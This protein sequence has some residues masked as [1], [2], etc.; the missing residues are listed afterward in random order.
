MPSISSIGRFE[1][2]AAGLAV[3]VPVFPGALADFPHRGVHHV[4]I[5][6]IDLNIRAAGVLIFVERFLPGFAAVGGGKDSAL[7]VWSVG[8]AH[9][10]SEQAIWIARIDGQGGDLLAVAQAEVTPRFSRV[11]GFVNPIA[12]R[13]VGALQA[14]A[15]G[16]VNNIWIGGSYGN[17]ADGLRRL[18]FKD[19]RPSAAVIVGFP[20]AAVTLSDVKDAG[21]VRHAGGGASS[22]SAERSDHAPAHFLICAQ[23]ILLGFGDARA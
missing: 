17:G 12:D 5:C 20:N 6:R 18:V 3:F 8:M 23:G 9:H 10:G 11:R 14:F 22:S 2:A 15:A 4:G 19:R 7:F 21:L 13:K 1:K 16:G